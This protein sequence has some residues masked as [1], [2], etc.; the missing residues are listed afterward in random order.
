MHTRKKKKTIQNKPNKT[1]KR[2]EVKNTQ[3]HAQQQ[4]KSR[5][6]ISAPAHIC[7][8]GHH[9]VNATSIFSKCNKIT[10]QE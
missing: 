10:S 2:R 7:L 8:I 6:E 4:Q 3:T 9:S 1:S 5:K